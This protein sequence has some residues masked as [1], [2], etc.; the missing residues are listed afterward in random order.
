MIAIKQTT[1]TCHQGTKE[2][3]ALRNISL[4]IATGVPVP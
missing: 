4:T 3:N 2:I 1:K